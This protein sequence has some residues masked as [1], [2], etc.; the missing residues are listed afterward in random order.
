ME[1]TL[2]KSGKWLARRACLHF[3][4]SLYAPEL[5]YRYLGGGK[6]IF[7]NGARILERLGMLNP[8][9]ATDL[10]LSKPDKTLECAI[11]AE[12]CG[13]IWTG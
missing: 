7:E 13:R 10:R 6:E 9:R 8:P 12:G 2:W 11:Q 1:P 5:E 3:L 4:G